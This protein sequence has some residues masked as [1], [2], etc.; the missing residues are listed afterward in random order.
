M[1]G[2]YNIKAVEAM[3]GIPA[4]TLRMWE[5]RYQMIAPQRSES[6]HRLYTDEQV[7]MLR[8]IVAKT[9]E[10]LTVRQ[11]I[12]LLETKEETDDAFSSCVQAAA[13]FDERKLK[14][15]WDEWMSVYSVEK[16]VGEQFPA[17][18]EAL[19]RADV[20]TSAHRQFAYTL[21]ASKLRMMLLTFSSQ[22]K[23]TALAIAP[24]ED[25]LPLLFVS[26]Y[27]S[28]RGI[29]VVYMNGDVSITDVLAAVEQVKPAF[30]LF[31]C[32]QTDDA[33]W[34]A[35][36]KPHIACTIGVTGKGM[37]HHSCYIGK[38]KAEWEKKLHL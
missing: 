22:S 17:L 36:M 23:Q 20:L 16:V 28:I 30:F 21:L 32:H 3:V 14:Q 13:S 2:K 34:L 1:T 18:Y 38:T 35:A 31:S 10:G 24:K 25:S 12:A 9:K 27:L 8:K 19:S 33:G 4:G 5:R 11:A 15:L 37:E 29:H 7:E 26:T 6:G